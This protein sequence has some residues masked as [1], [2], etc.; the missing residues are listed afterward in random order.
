MISILFNDIVE[1]SLMKSVMLLLMSC[2]NVLFSIANGME[3]WEQTDT[4]EYKHEDALLMWRL[5]TLTYCSQE[6]LTVCIRAN[7]LILRQWIVSNASL[8][9]TF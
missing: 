7:S 5:N 1:Y 4:T 6:T 9:R 3:I 8:L 2:I